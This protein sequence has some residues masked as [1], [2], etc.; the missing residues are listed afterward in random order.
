ME[1]RDQFGRCIEWTRAEKK[2]VREMKEAGLQPC[3]H[4][5]ALRSKAEWLVKMPMRNASNQDKKLPPH[6]QVVLPRT[7]KI[8]SVVVVPDESG[9]GPSRL[10]QQSVSKPYVIPNEEDTAVTNDAE[11][12]AGDEDCLIMDGAYEVHQMAL[13]EVPV[14]DDKI[15]TEAFITDE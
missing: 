3:K 6:L 5:L 13:E 1:Q 12:V 11:V 2:M 14:I 15:A 4:V 8:R 7:P 10:S 9:V